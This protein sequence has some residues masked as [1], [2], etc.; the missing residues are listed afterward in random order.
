MSSWN[1]ARE[2]MRLSVEWA[3]QILYHL[4]STATATPFHLSS[5]GIEV[6]LEPDPDLVALL[7]FAID[8]YFVVM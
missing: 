8:Q 1:D 6:E 5:G 4:S 7:S 3:S 2:S